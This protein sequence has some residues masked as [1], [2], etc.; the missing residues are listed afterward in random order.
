ME[1]GWRR[2]NCCHH[3]SNLLPDAC[4]YDA[5]Y[6]CGLW[7]FCW[8]FC[9]VYS[10][11]LYPLTNHWLSNSTSCWSLIFFIPQINARWKYIRY[12]Q[13]YEKGMDMMV[14]YFLR[15]LRWP[16]PLYM[17]FLSLTGFFF[18]TSHWTLVR[19]FSVQLKQ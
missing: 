14:E 12:D 10:T 13:L 4:N 17:A 8:Y 6:W 3:F 16:P 11:K 7:E 1:S 2:V 18:L 19:S 5:M 15:Q 9:F